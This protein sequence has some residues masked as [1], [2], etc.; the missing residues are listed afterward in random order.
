MRQRLLY[1]A[2]IIALSL[3]T[4]APSANAATWSHSAVHLENLRIFP[5]TSDSVV[6]A[7]S[8]SEGG[9]SGIDVPLDGTPQR[10][11]GRSPAGADPRFATD[12]G[13]D[14]LAHIKLACSAKTSGPQVGVRFTNARALPLPGSTCAQPVGIDANTKGDV[15]VMTGTE[16]RGSVRHRSYSR[17]IYVKGAGDVAFRRVLRFTVLRNASGGA[18]AIGESGAVQVAWQDGTIWKSKAGVTYARYRT[19]AGRWQ[20][21]QRF[22]TSFDAP[23]RL[24]DVAILANDRRL[25]LWN[26]DHRVGVLA[27]ATPNEAFHDVPV[28]G[29]CSEPRLAVSPHGAQA[30]LAGYSCDGARFRMEAMNIA[31]DGTTSPIEDIALPG[32]GK[33]G[34]P[35]MG[36]LDVADNGLALLTWSGWLPGATREN[37]HAVMAAVRPAGSAQFS[38]ADLIDPDGWAISGTLTPDGHAVIGYNG[39][40]WGKIV[41]AKP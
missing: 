3:G 35:S 1:P 25:L 21:V 8:A 19:A 9:S 5:S 14:G 22:G 12:A 40:S 30:L 39:P 13:P 27:T 41:I 15:V 33:A 26:P 32:T 2:A 10:F 23:T 18:V 6:Y 28:E 38:A 31:Q 24:L 4:L 34:W 17:S 36:T 20:S 11:D 37:Q 7:D 16:R 29:P